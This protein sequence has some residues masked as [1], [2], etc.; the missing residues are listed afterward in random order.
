MVV[1]N[2]KKYICEHCNY[3]TDSLYHYNRHCQTNKHRTNINAIPPF[4]CSQNESFCSQNEQNCSKKEQKKGGFFLECEF[5]DKKFTLK[6]NLTRHSN[7]CKNRKITNVAKTLDEQ[8]K[9]I[10]EKTCEIETLKNKINSMKT[11][12]DSLNYEKDELE[13]E[14]KDILKK[15]FDK[16]IKDDQKSVNINYFNM[17]YVIQNFKEVQSIED[18]LKEPLD[19]EEIEYMKKNSPSLSASFLINKRLMQDFSVDKRPVH[20]V[21]QPR[22]KMLVKS[23]DGWE[24][25]FKGRK[26]LDKIYPKISDQYKIDDSVDMQSRLKN[27]DGIIN[28]ELKNRSVILNEMIN[29][30]L[31]KN[32]QT[33]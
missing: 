13:R 29:N 14:N 23:D 5:C 20:C 18:L 10:T 2:K 32:D 16:H 3:G 7:N 22:K 1:K 11:L 8:D 27:M 19:L 6:R 17:N 9:T 12:I 26:L 24:V 21:D 25:D 31:L 28:M 30:C 15:V 4:C 33:L